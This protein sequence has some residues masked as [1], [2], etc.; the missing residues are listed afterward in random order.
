MVRVVLAF[1][2]IFFSI[3]SFVAFPVA[4]GVLTLAN[5]DR[6]HGELVL[7][8]KD[9]VVWKSHNFG[10]IRIEKAKILSLDTEAE[11]KIAGRDEP[12]ALAGHRREQWELYCTEGEGW[13]MDFPAIERAEPYVEFSGNPV[14]YHGKVAAAGVFEHGN[15]ERE[16]W[17]V[18]LRLDIRSG[19]WHHLP[20]VNYQ[21]LTNSE[22]Q[23]Q[24]KYLLTYDLRWIFAEKWFAAANSAVQREDARN[25][26][27]GSTIGLGLGYL[28]YDTSNRALSVQGGISSLRERFINDALD[29][30]Q[31][32][33]YAAARTAVNYRYK[34]PTGQEIFLDQ[35]WLQS[36]DEREDYQGNAKL[37][38][39][40]PLVR[41]ILMEVA[42]HWL[43][44]NTPSLGNQKEDTKMT[45]GV[46][47]E[48]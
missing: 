1:G 21:N 42:Y 37:G 25:L 8:E 39:R 2:C 19:D 9:H 18:N 20:A 10:E 6:V 23:S 16:D 31:Q 28:F 41:G 24:E 17:D 34:F 3:L 5:G 32:N 35:E 36:L 33:S 44:D 47:Y 22:V 38:L 13:V 30:K 14:I 48:W 15:R 29:E 7:V 46:G 45:L 40:T 43:Y 26:D 12:C 11:L 27:L 4:A